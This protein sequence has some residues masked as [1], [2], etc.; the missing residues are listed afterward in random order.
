MRRGGG[1]RFEERWLSC[2]EESWACAELDVAFRGGV[3]RAALEAEPQCPVTMA[4]VP[5]TKMNNTANDAI[6]TCEYPSTN[7]VVARRSPSTLPPDTRISRRA[8]CPV[9]I[10]INAPTKG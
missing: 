3:L 5:I 4:N 6:A 7:P 2:C 1:G 8:K 10:A 9:T